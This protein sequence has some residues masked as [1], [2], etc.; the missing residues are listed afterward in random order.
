MLRKL[1]PQLRVVAFLSHVQGDLA[2]QAQA[3]GCAE[4]MPRSAFTQNLAAILE[5][6]KD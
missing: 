6:A 3:A 4:V 2:A 1:H 5:P